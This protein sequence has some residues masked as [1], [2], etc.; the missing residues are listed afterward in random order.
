M[1]N[2]QQPSRLIGFLHWETNDVDEACLALSEGLRRV[3]QVIVP[4]IPY[5]IASNTATLEWLTFSSVATSSTA[6]RAWTEPDGRNYLLM[7]WNQG[8]NEYRLHGHQGTVEA[9][10]GLISAPHWDSYWRSTDERDAI[11]VSI[12]ATIL[13]R[14]A[15]NLAGRPLRSPLNPMGVL[16]KKGPIWRILNRL[17]GFLE[18][19]LFGKPSLL[20]KERQRRLITAIVLGTPH[21][22]E[23][24]EERAHSG[25]AFIARRYYHAREYMEAHLTESITGGDLAKATGTTTRGLQRTFEHYGERWTGVLSKMRMQAARRDLLNPEE[26]TTVNSVAHRYGFHPSRFPTEYFKIFGEYPLSTLQLARLG[27]KL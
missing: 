18:N 24:R 11:V 10:E 16:Q 21:N 22:I 5:G 15:E 4:R 19:G 23:L 1:P 8:A 2:R 25:A 26:H 12:P 9:G 20:R 17:L 7:F 6:Q 27:H 13:M 3:R 14:E